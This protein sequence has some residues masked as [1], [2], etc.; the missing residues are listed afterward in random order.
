MYNNYYNN[1]NT[2]GGMPFNNGYM[3][4]QQPPVKQSNPLTNEEIASLRNTAGQFTL[5]LTKDE[6][7][8][9]ICFH[10]DENGNQTTIT[11][12]DGST[13][14]TLC[15]KTW[16][17]DEQSPEQVQDAVNTI[18]SILQTIKLLYINFPDQAAREYYQIIPLIEKIPGLYKIAS[19]NFHMYE[20]N[21]LGGYA[22]GAMNPF[23]VFGQLGGFQNMYQY[24]QTNPYGQPAGQPMMGGMPQQN[25][26]NPIYGQPQA[27]PVAQPAPAV[28]AGQVAG[29]PFDPNSNVYTQN[30]AAYAPAMQGYAYQAGVTPAP[31][32]AAPAPAAAPVA[33]TG[34]VTT[35]GDHTP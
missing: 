4:N 25:M 11:N 27:A 35:S 9:G 26:Y 31:Q 22:N 8:R 10:R 14:C 6:M 15:G 3:Y 28:G 16:R 24:Q 30:P 5:A 12:P 23:A 20:G 18:L 1:P 7:I 17:S 2:M 33:P 29:N 13:T 32:P 19:D 34:E 21:Y